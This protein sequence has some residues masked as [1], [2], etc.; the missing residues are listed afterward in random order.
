MRR[1]T[2]PEFPALGGT[3]CSQPVSG[4]RGAHRLA[5]NR[6]HP[7]PVTHQGGRTALAPAGRV[8]TAP[9]NGASNRARP[10]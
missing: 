2:T 10:R 7:P 4:G 1:L 5:S 8:V 9:T 6:C 3:G